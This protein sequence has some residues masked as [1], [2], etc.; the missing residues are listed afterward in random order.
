LEKKVDKH[1]SVIESFILAA[2]EK[3]VRNDIEDLKRGGFRM[4]WGQIIAF[5]RPELF[6][7]IIFLWCLGLFLKKAPWFTAEWM[8]P[9][10]LLAVSLIITIAYTAIV[11]NE[12]FTAVV[13][14]TG[15]IQGVIIAAV[16]VFGNEM[17]KQATVKR[18]QEKGDQ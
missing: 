13:F 6:I 3:G 7:L 2:Q 17:I 5:I 9:F 11:I 18:L 16:T 14:V 4:D 8:I 10:I 1:I 15:I 12:G